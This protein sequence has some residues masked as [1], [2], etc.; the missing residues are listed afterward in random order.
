MRAVRGEAEIAEAFARCRS[1]AASAFG[2]GSLYA[3]RL[4]ASARHIEVQILGDRRGGLADF[5]ERE[6]TIQ[7]RHQKLIEIAPS[8]SLTPRLRDRIIG[9]AMQIARAA[10]YDSL[11]T[12]E[13]LL[14]ATRFD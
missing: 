4:I 12:F 11:G 1:E 9:A 13:F 10:R 7:R 6:C 2:D 5:G 3:E 14:D 8:P